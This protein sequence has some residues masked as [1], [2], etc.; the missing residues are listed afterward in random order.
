VLRA[1]PFS[2]L[3]VIGLVNRR[4]V[5]FF[6]DLSNRGFAGDAKAREFVVKAKPSYGGRSVPTPQVLFMTPE[7][8]IVAEES[9]YA[10]E[11]QF[12]R[13]LKKVIA[14]NPDYMKP[15]AG[16]A[17]LTTPEAR[18]RL[19][20]DLLDYPRAR[21]ELKEAHSDYA[22]FLRGHLDRRAGRWTEMKGNF[23]KVRDPLFVDDVR[24]EKAYELWTEGQYDELRK[25]LAKF[26]AVSNRYSE[27]RYFE[28]LALYH[29]GKVK[30]ARQTWRSTIESCPQDNWV[31]RADWAFCGTKEGKTRTG[32]SSMGP[33]T[34]CLNRI[35]YMGRKNPD[36]A[37][38]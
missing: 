4:F 5:P 10:S 33:R 36:L 31:Y 14:A 34:S 19:A 35:G 2:D 29:L 11:E 7:G 37:K 38:R 26:P 6:F 16:E 1:G 18:A 12:L 24:M 13:T 9:N 21:R 20:C 27:A 25:A 32:F 22:H 3:R 28:G 30:E 23:A 15:A 17:K 8:K